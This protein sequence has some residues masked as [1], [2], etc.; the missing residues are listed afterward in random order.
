MRNRLSQVWELVSAVV[1]LVAVLGCGLVVLPWCWY[2]IYTGLMGTP[3][4]WNKAVLGMFVL[5]CVVEPFFVGL[6]KTTRG[7][8]AN[9]TN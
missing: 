1:A 7:K 5:V 8:D 6:L 9:R 2:L 4:E 3:P